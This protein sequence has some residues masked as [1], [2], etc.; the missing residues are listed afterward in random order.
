MVVV[1]DGIEPVGALELDAPEALAPNAAVADFELALVFGVTRDRITVE[2]H[3]IQSKYFAP[4]HC[5]S[6]ICVGR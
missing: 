6:E 5:L 3:R 2:T 1:M 4:S